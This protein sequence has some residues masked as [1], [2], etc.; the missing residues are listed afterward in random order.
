[1]LRGGLRRE[2]AAQYLARRSANG[3]AGRF[4]EDIQVKLCDRREFLF[5]EW[6]ES[7]KKDCDEKSPIAKKNF[8]SSSGYK[9]SSDEAKVFIHSLL[10]IS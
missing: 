7:E 2:G 9:L 5:E 3:G 4:T 1:M 10:I 6:N 8:A